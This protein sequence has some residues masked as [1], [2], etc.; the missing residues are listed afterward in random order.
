MSHTTSSKQTDI[1]ND[2]TGRNGHAKLTAV[3]K[4][5]TKLT[6]RLAGSTSSTSAAASTDSSVRKSPEPFASAGVNLQRFQS[7]HGDFIIGSTADERRNKVQRLLLQALGTPMKEPQINPVEIAIRIEAAMQMK[8]QKDPNA[9]RQKYR[10]LSFN[11]KDDQ[12]PD[13]KASL[14]DGRLPPEDLV[15]MEPHELAS[16]ELKKQR[17]AE[18]KYAKEATRSDYWKGRNTTDMFTCGKCKQ[19]KCTY[20][21]MQTRSADEPMTVFVTCVNCGNRWRC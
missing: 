4:S 2:T 17:E 9:Y 21:Q 19:K 18:R 5:D 7:G 12:N 6:I 15:H 1:T 11:L 16:E 20:Y 14:F 8:Y 13:L 10:D 3:N